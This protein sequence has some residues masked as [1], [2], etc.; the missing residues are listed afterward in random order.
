MHTWKSSTLSLFE[1][2]NYCDK[3]RVTL[4]WT[5]GGFLL[6]K[7]FTTANSFTIVTPCKIVNWDHYFS[8]NTK[9]QGL[10]CTSSSILIKQKSPTTYD[11]KE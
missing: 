10:L 7:Q 6:S 3:G 11:Q 2:N 4:V 1:G 8:G 5:N 9:Y